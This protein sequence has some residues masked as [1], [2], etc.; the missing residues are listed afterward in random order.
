MNEYGFKTLTKR[1]EHLEHKRRDRQYAR[2]KVYTQS[3]Q[4]MLNLMSHYRTLARNQPGFT[5]KCFYWLVIAVQRAALKQ[6]G[7]PHR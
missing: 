6:A 1:I 4:Y 2:D 5:P 3:D 7:R